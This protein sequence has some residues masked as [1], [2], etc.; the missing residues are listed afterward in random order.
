MP[1]QSA[2]T[3]MWTRFARLRWGRVC[4]GAVP[5]AAA[6]TG[7]WPADLPAVPDEFCASP[8]GDE[9]RV[10]PA[11]A[12]GRPASGSAHEVDPVD[13]RNQAGFAATAQ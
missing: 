12:G 11:R 5:G 2:A 4:D 9:G 7:M 6:V 8:Y 10:C 13:G 3:D 1:A